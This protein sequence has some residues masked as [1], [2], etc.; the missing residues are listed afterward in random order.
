MPGK[1]A[2]MIKHV[3]KSLAVSLE[4][5]P[6]IQQFYPEVELGTGTEEIHILKKNKT[7][8]KALETLCWRILTAAVFIQV[9]IR[10]GPHKGFDLFSC[11]GV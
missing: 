3:E 4:V 1:I 8:N 2:K 9:R 7:K 10:N 5:Y 11:N 6:M